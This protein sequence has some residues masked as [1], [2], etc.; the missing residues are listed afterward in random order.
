MMGQVGCL[1]IGR[2]AAALATLGICALLLAS[3]G[4]SAVFM[5][6]DL[7]VVTDK[8]AYQVGDFVNA[9]VYVMNSGIPTDA[10]SV[11]LAVMAYGSWDPL[12]NV[13]L[14][15]VATG[16]YRGTFQVTTNL[17]SLWMPGLTLRSQVSVGYLTDSAST[18]IS[19]PAR[20]SV[21][22][23]LSLSVSSAVPGETVSGTLTVT[24]N[25][26]LRDADDLNV[27]ASLVTSLAQQTAYLPVT[28]ISV[29][30]YRFYYTVPSSLHA[31]A[32]VWFWGRVTIQQG[33][34]SYGY[35]DLATLPVELPDPF[36]IWYD[37]VLW[38]TDSVRLN[39]WLAGPTGIPAWGAKV[40][41]YPVAPPFFRVKPVALSATADPT[42]LA[43]FDVRNPASYGA[44]Y[45]TFYGYATMGTSNQSFSGTAEDT[46]LTNA[47]NSG[48]QLRRNNILDVF[49][50]GDTA[51]LNYTAFWNGVPLN[52]THFVYDVHDATA[53]LAYG[54]A[55]ASA[56]GTLLLSFPMPSDAA[57]VDVSAHL[58][59]TGWSP[60]F[61]TVR[62]EMRLA[63]RVG[64]FQVGATTRLT[65][66][67]PLGHSA[68][69]V[70][71]MFYP[72]SLSA[73]PDLQPDWSESPDGAGVFPGV[74]MAVSNSSALGVSL[75]L[76]S[77][78][79]S[80]RSFYLEIRA[81]PLDLGASVAIPYVLKQLVYVGAGSV[82]PDNGL[83]VPS[84]V[85]GLGVTAV[86][87]WVALVIRLMPRR[88]TPFRA[89]EKG[90]S[91]TLESPRQARK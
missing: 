74:V 20:V 58:P 47:S 82:G 30:V 62:P 81:E 49:P 45:L 67:L 6:L 51:I 39:V 41:L 89:R 90:T 19:V 76:P 52:G 38:T 73:Y 8:T 44:G 88:R 14:S 35:A 70:S 31:S 9:T 27:S 29:G 28:H 48:L 5:T 56:S 72:Y 68:W 65:A 53:L 34:N 61:D 75:T 78:L 84:L 10:D 21:R 13:P 15:R 77:F 4:T 36:L 64:R 22:G 2:R 83:L 85:L 87:I 11:S 33:N 43:A 16:T 37:A 60:F 50:P 59:N 54:N 23:H 42:G 57:T 71:V 55:T 80:N 18:D 86:A 3:Q 12:E 17:T 63:A 26:A 25:G 24:Y 1:A 79:P 40:F 32:S 66:Q 91:L 7:V 69:Q 46:L